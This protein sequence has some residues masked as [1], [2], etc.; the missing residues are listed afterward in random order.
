MS[1]TPRFQHARAALEAYRE[2]YRILKVATPAL[3]IPKLCICDFG[4]HSHE[5]FHDAVASHVAL[6]MT[7][8]ANKI[9]VKQVGPPD[10]MWNTLVSKA[11]AIVLLPE[12]EDFEER[13]LQA[14]QKDKPIIRTRP[15]G[16][17][18]S[19]VQNNEN[20]YT[21][22]AADTQAM[23]ECLLQ[24]RVEWGKHQQKGIPMPNKTWDEVTTVG[25]AVS[26]LFL[27][28]SLSKGETVEPQDEQIYR[29]A[30]RSK[31]TEMYV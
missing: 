28:S 10:Q 25:N 22:G 17:Y 31:D 27:A 21:I 20:V 4:A 26:W 3:R 7:D 30:Q 5:E 15:L 24:I 18:Y 13:F 9:C 11:E 2:Y 1:N 6:H 16:P 14:V 8:L 12:G 19:L 23:T 29:L